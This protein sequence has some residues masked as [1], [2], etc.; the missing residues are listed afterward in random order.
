[1]AASRR[2]RSSPRCRSGPSATAT[3][4]SGNT[5]RRTRPK[6]P[7]PRS[8]CASSASAHPS[9]PV[10]RRCTAAHSEPRPKPT[11]EKAWRS[12]F[13]T[14]SSR[15]PQA[16]A[17]HDDRSR[18]MWRRASRPS[19][20]IDGHRDQFPPRSDDL[21]RALCEQRLA[22]G[23]AQADVEADVGQRGADRAGDRGSQRAA[24]RRRDHDRSTKAA[25]CNM[26]VWIIPGHAKDSHHGVRGLRPHARR[27][28]RQRHRLQRLRAARL[29]ESVFRRGADRR[30]P[31][32]D[33]DLVGTQDHWS[34]EGRNILR[35]ATLDEFKK[36]PAFVKEMEHVKLDKTH[37][38]LQGRRISR[39]AVGH[40]DRP[41]HVHR[42]HGVRDRVRGREQH[43]G[44]RQG[45]G[46]AQ[47]R[48]ALAAHRSLF[49]GRS[50]IRPTLITSRCPASSARTRPAKWC[51]R[52]RRPCTAAKA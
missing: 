12:G 51:A 29:D 49:L 3:T 45:A 47:P 11:F 5:G 42:L 36:N 1:M 50:S 8:R 4:S 6:V 18:L 9:K 43:S 31:A 48:D 13:T 52:W 39:P 15:A 32:I 23:T 33:Y 19:T 25:T 20:P 40:G 22:A 7:G 21:R 38:A 2:T 24:K 37:L 26:P 34:I 17:E 46:G 35:S 10:A 44:G 16:T 30:A 14:A 27:P 28:H 41:E